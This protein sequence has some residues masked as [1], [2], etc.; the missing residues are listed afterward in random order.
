MAKLQNQ[1]TVNTDTETAE[2]INRIAEHYQRKPAELLRLL[3]LPVLL[4]EWAKIQT[5]EHP[6]NLQTWA[7]L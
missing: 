2:L 1:F 6:E 4:D 7:R 3:L 5:V